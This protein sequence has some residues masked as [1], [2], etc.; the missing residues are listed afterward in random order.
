MSNSGKLVIA[1]WCLSAAFMGCSTEPS[2]SPQ[3]EKEDATSGQTQEPS[4]L[5]AP[6]TDAE[7]SPDIV[8]AENVTYA[9]VDERIS[10][11]PIKTQIEQHIVVTGIPSSAGLEAEIR[12][13]YRAALGRRG[14]K[15]HNPPSNIYIYV[16]GSEE[17]AR[18]GQGLW[19]GMLAKSY[20]DTGDPQ[21][22][23]NQDRLV[24]LSAVPEER[25]GLAESKRKD[26]F[27]EI[28]AAGDRATREAM[29]RVPDSEIMKQIELERELTQQYK[30]DVARKYALTEDVLVEIGVEGIKKGWSWP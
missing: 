6:T 10:D 12:Q 27:R 18:A 11:M 4:S 29:A 25:F 14:F 9:L 3:V 13:R 23:I 17:Q 22:S 16:Y 19:I 7:I 24:A 1:L 20:S 21:I 5:A 26:V 2:P 28:V 8:P 15:Y 30:R